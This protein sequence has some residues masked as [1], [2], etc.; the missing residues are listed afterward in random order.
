MSRITTIAPN[1]ELKSKM[2]RNAGDEK[3][4]LSY[5]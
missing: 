4:R 1:D 5:E 3:R 2:Q